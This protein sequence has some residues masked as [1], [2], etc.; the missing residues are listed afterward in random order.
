MVPG[1]L[2]RPAGRGRR[3]PHPHQPR[4]PAVGLPRRPPRRRRPHLVRRLR[5]RRRGGPAIGGVLVDIS[6]RW[7][8]EVNIPIGIAAVVLA[9]RLV[10]DSREG[11]TAR[12]PDL[13]GTAVLTLAVALLALGVVKVNDWPGEQTTLVIGAALLGLTWFWLRSL[14]HPAPVIEPALLAVRT[15]FW[16]NAAILLFTVAFAANLLLGVLWMQQVWHYSPIKTGLAVAPG[17][18]MVP[19]MALIAGRLVA[20]RV[21]VGL[22]TAVGCMLCAFGVVMIAMSLGPAPAYATEMLPGWLIGGTGVGLALPTILSASAA[23]LPSHRYATGSAVVNMS[24]QIGTVLGVSLAVA[25]L[26]TPHGYADA[27]TAYV[28]S[29]L[30]VGG[31]MVI[32]AIAALGMT[33]RRLQPSRPVPEPE[34]EVIAGAS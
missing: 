34:T 30:M 7:V 21:P 16:S 25:V 27:H 26:G 24:R 22:I 12:V 20:A 11:A 15:F 13:P 2:P 17:P 32:A 14:R 18:L 4:A 9:V 5:A 3:R 8:F 31:F 33:P 19:I 23:D 1:R 28:N 10:P 6:W 29:W